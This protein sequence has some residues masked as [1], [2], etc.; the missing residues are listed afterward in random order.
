MKTDSF[1]IGLS[2]RGILHLDIFKSGHKISEEN[3]NLIVNT[4]ATILAKMLGGQGTYNN[5][6]ITKIRVSD[7]NAIV[8]VAKTDLDG[9]NKFTKDID[10]VT[11]DGG[12]P[13][14]VQFNF[15]LNDTEFNGYDIWQF[16]LF[17]ADGQMFSMLSRNPDKEYPIEKD[18]D[19][20]V[21]G[22]WKIQFTNTGS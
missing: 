10:S 8:G 17:N 19:V 22:W 18:S 20:T 12:S 3:H 21:S 5:V 9:S 15:S 4:S 14:D 2:V 1:N 16:G 7:G 13:G 11:Y 6:K